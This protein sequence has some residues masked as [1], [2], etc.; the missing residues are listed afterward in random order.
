MSRCVERAE[1]VAR[2]CEVT[3]N[4]LLDA[5]RENESTHWAALIATSGDGEQAK[6]YQPGVRSDVIRFLTCDAEY[7][8]RFCHPWLLLVKRPSV[9]EVI[10]RDMWLALNDF[11]LM[12]KNTE[13]DPDDPEGL[14]G[15][16]QRQAGLMF[17]GTTDATWSHREPWHF[18]RM[19]R[20]IERADKTSRI[21]DVKYFVL[22]PNSTY[23]G[24][25]YDQL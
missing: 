11:Y 16:Y 24:T 21:L 8:N 17:E 22:L 23:V 10:S 3:L 7:P 14:A 5:P 20:M 12:V 13:I 9:R 6:R 15:F 18:S 1:N 2:F 25:T 4:M 19:G